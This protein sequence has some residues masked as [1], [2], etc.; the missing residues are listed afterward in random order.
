MG[1]EV[2]VAVAMAHRRLLLLCSSPYCCGG[3]GDQRD[4][5]GTIK[6]VVWLSLKNE[7]SALPLLSA[8]LMFY[9]WKE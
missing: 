9:F 3:D 7:S 4:I 1:L 5:D 6:C 2:S 8:G